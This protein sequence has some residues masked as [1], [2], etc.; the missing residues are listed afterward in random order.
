MDQSLMGIG[1]QRDSNFVLTRRQDTQ[2]IPVAV[3]T[4][5]FPMGIL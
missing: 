5:D 1:I 4:G 2:V 3:E